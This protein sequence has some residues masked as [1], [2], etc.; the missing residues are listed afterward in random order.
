MDVAMTY[1]KRQSERRHAGQCPR[2]PSWLACPGEYLGTRRAADVRQRM[3]QVAV[4]GAFI[5]RLIDHEIGAGTG[6][7]GG[8]TG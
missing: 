5:D 6:I 2:V 3:S 8:H 7:D 1:T 4:A